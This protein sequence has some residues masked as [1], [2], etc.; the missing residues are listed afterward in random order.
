MSDNTKQ[1]LIIGGIALLLVVFL[2]SRRSVAASPGSFHPVLVKPGLATYS[3]EETW[4]VQYNSDGMPTKVTIHRK[5]VQ[6]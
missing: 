1:L 6:N 3:N 4:D 5:A 2:T